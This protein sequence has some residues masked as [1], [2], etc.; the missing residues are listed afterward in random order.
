MPLEGCG[1]HRLQAPKRINKRV[2]SAVKKTHLHSVSSE[3]KHMIVFPFTKISD[4][5]RWHDGPHPGLCDLHHLKVEGW[6]LSSPD[7]YPESLIRRKSSKKTNSIFI[8]LPAHRQENKQV[9]G[10]KGYL[11]DLNYLRLGFWICDL[12]LNWL[13]REKSK[14]NWHKDPLQL[15]HVAIFPSFIPRPRTSQGSPISQCL[16]K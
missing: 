8:L 6:H 1:K 15:L 4:G 10:E 11:V 7:V 5:E 14:F 13:T 3:D 9:K 12:S 16:S 2:T